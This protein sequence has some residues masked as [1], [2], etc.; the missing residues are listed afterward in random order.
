MPDDNTGHKTVDHQC[1]PI[2]LGEIDC[3]WPLPSLHSS[4]RVD[5]RITTSD[6]LI[7]VTKWEGRHKSSDRENLLLQVIW[8]WAELPVWCKNIFSAIMI[9]TLIY[10]L[11]TIKFFILILASRILL[12]LNTRVSTGSVRESAVWWWDDVRGP[13]IPLSD[14]FWITFREAHI[15]HTHHDKILFGVIASDT[16]HHHIILITTLGFLQLPLGSLLQQFP[17]VSTKNTES[18]PG[19][20]CLQ[21]EL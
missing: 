5:R 1:C 11:F 9:V 14:Q 4:C 20:V 16:H 2:M 10:F 21:K 15:S 6:Y 19:T 12:S 17:F 3:V 8:N 18:T 13:G 7:R